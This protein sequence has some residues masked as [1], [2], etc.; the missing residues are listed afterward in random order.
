M[1][2][3]AAFAYTAAL[4]HLLADKNQVQQIGDTTVVCWAEGADPVCP[5]P[6]RGGDLWRRGPGGLTDNA[7]RTTLRRLAPRGA[8]R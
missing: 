1:G 2:K 6:C 4:N 5:E 3:Y 7:L 8:L